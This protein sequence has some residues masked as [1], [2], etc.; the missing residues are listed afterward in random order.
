MMTFQ[1]KIPKGLI[2]AAPNSGAGKTTVMLGLCKALSRQGI[3]VKPF[4]NGPDYIDPAFHKLAT[5][6]N[7][8]N[9]DS[10]AMSES[11][12][13]GEILASRSDLVLLEGSMGFFDGVAKS[14]SFGTGTTADLARLTGWP[15][16]LVLNVSGQAQSAAAV[17]TGFSSYDPSV[18]LAGVILNNVASPRHQALIENGMAYAG[19][20]ILG[21]LPR[22]TDLELPERHLGLIQAQEISNLNSILE[23]LSDFMIKNSS[24][25]AILD[26]AA[27]KSETFSPEKAHFIKPPGQR[28]A[29]SKDKAFAFIYPH[30]INSWREQG[31]EI[32][33]FSPLMDESPKRDADAVW[34]SG[35]YPE[36]YA[37]KIAAS[38]NFLEGI[39]KFSDSKPVHGECGGYMVMGKGIIDAD[40]KY[41]E[42]AGILGLETSFEKRKI[43]LGYRRAKIISDAPSLGK[44]DIILG[45][46]FHYSSILS[47][48]D[49]PLAEIKDANNQVVN[50][51]GSRRN[52]SSGTFFHIIARGE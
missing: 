11:A 34:L 1:N 37:G 4:K 16:I 27:S 17:A 33:P 22:N 2:I 36:L 39:R 49:P 10:W 46:E 29:I 14:G 5:G 24:L 47:Q 9:L 18:K 32:I 7:S 25:D 50:E 52:N 31:A 21:S 43:N 23:K 30:I 13:L 3:K 51:T 12:I 38:N 26:S 48:P 28:V 41:H 6:E 40:G 8:G 44:N 20:N 19:V 35:G 15:V 42:M 45:H